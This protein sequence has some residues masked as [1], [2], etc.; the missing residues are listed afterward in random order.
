MPAPE[1]LG[2]DAA[3]VHFCWVQQGI[4][5]SVVPQTWGLSPWTGGSR[6]VVQACVFQ[7][8][9]PCEVIFGSVK[10]KFITLKKSFN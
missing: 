8:L 3:W 2:S 1:V 7:Y 5:S 9:G 10:I 4:K 6:H